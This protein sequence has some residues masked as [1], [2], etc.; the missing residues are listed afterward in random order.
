MMALGRRCN[1]LA[2]TLARGLL[3]ALHRRTPPPQQVWLAAMLH[4]LDAVPH[5]IARL[6]WALGAVRVL[7]TVGRTRRP[8]SPAPQ[9]RRLRSFVFR[10][11]LGS[12]E[13]PERL[14]PLP[15]SGPVIISWAAAA[16]AGA[17]VVVLRGSL[18][19]SPYAFN[20]GA[21]APA[22]IHPDLG[23]GL[24]RAWDAIVLGSAAEVCAVATILVLFLRFSMKE[25]PEQQRL[26]CRDL[27]ISLQ[28]GAGLLW[29]LVLMTSA[30]GLEAHVSAASLFDHASR[31]GS[32]Y[33]T[34]GS[35]RDLVLILAFAAGLSTLAGHLLRPAEA[36]PDTSP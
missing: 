9:A 14:E 20:L 7:L 25:T 17:A 5:G 33:L 11:I 1:R 28:I 8:T 32:H 6:G 22:G 3:A 19:D 34:W 30:W 16:L 4:E 35:W 26:A 15:G 24:S 23:D 21:G 18:E 13:V 10:T 2:S 36:S 12:T 29:L 31:S 27:R